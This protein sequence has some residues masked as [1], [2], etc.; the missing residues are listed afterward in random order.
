[1]KQMIYSAVRTQPEQLAVGE[2]KGFDYY[3]LS[4]GTHPCAYID[5]TDTDLNGKDLCVIDL[6]CHGGITYAEK[7]L[8]TVDKKGWFIGWDYAHYGDYTGD[9]MMFPEDIQMGGR[10]WKTEEIVAECKA[11]IDRIL[12]NEFEIL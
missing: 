3:V 12:N 11:V 2:Y 4:M 1:M 6:E 8:Q 9:Q 7:S 5:V 10:E